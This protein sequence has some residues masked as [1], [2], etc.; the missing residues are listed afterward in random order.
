MD[1]KKLAKEFADSLKSLTPEEFEHYFP[2]DKTPKGWVSI[3]ETLPKFLAKD[4]LQ[5]GSVYRVRYK[6]DKTGS[7]MVGD[8]NT[9]YYMAKEEGITHWYNE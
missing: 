4:F 7:S 2:E 1:I 6:D 8:H 9:W 5:G 3:E